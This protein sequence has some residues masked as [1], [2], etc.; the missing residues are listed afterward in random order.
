MY[1]NRPTSV[2][3]DIAKYKQIIIVNYTINDAVAI[4]NVRTAKPT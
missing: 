1:A 3:N 2:G 4:F